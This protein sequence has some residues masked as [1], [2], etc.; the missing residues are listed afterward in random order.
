MKYIYSLFIFAIPTLFTVHAQEIV[1]VYLTPKSHA[2]A[3]LEN[4]SLFLSNAA[5]N[6][7]KNRGV[8][9]DASD[10]PIDKNQLHYFKKNHIGYVGHSKWLNAVMIEV[11]N[12]QE[13]EQLRLLPFVDHL[14]SLVLDKTATNEDQFFAKPAKENRPKKYNNPYG[15]AYEYI[16]QINL[17]P[18]HQVGFKGENTTIAILDTGF[19]L[20]NLL[21]AFAHIYQENR[22]LDAYNFTTDNT[23]IYQGASHGTN[24]LSFIGAK[25]PNEYIGT[26][27][28]ANFL[29]Y[30]T[31]TTDYE[32]PKELMFWAQAAERADSVGVDVINTSLGYHY[33]DDPRYNYAPEHLDGQTS[34]ISKVADMAAQKGILVVAAAGNEGNFVWKKITP[35]ADA[36]HVFT[37]GSNDIHKNPSSFSSYGPNA[38]GELKPNV[39][40]MGQRT[41]FYLTSGFI[42]YGNGTS[43]SAPIVAGAMALLI[44]AFPTMP[45]DEL[46]GLVQSNSHLYPNTN[47]QLGYGTPDFY[48]VYQQLSLS[49]QKQ[50]EAAQNFVYPN[51][52]IDHLKFLHTEPSMEIVINDG[53]GNV[54]W[55]QSGTNTIS[56]PHWPKGIYF[57]TVKKPGEK[58]ITQK[59][60]KR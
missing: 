53:S 23:Q 10:V 19:P 27:P 60:I 5:Q 59:I 58:G 29:L 37:V 12:Q 38:L 45:L 46:K 51:P 7:K 8:A 3:F 17:D 2:T 44:Q 16:Q 14:E 41:P 15:Y 18:I 32:S 35:P 22:L 28:N 42:E 36:P 56:T 55:Q 39:S 48:K 30:T 52:F 4:P 34:L 43:Y 33:F 50:I 49:L 13:A 40:V 47:D 25:R 11:Q 24:V 31:E 6:K 57:L 9:L 26:A 1:L 21:P 20:V 54:V